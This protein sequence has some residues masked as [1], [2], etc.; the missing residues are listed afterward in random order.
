M[1]SFRTMD[2]VQSFPLSYRANRFSNSQQALKKVAALVP[3]A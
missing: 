2:F 3:E 1:Q